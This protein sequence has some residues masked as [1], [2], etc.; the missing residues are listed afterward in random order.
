MPAKGVRTA[1][2]E[3]ALIELIAARVGT[4]ATVRTGVGDDCAVLAGDP[5]LVLGHDMIVEGVDFRWST[6]APE[7]V[8]H[9]ALAVNLSDLAAM[10]AE[11]MAALVGLG[12]GPGLDERRAAGLYDGMRDLG[13]P[14]GCPVVGGDVSDSAETV[15]AVTVVGRMPTGV[16]P[17]LRSGGRPGDAV[18]VT[19]ALGASWAGLML[20]EDPALAGTVPEADA[21]ALRRAHRR[22]IPQ[23][24]AGQRLARAGVHALMDCSDGLPIDL[25]RL[26]RASGLRARLDLDR[27]PTAPGVTA[28]C[29]EL[30]LPADATA[31][32]GG[33]DLVL[34]ACLPPDAVAPVARA[35]GVALHVVG[36]LARGEP[37]LDVRRGGLPVT[38]ATPG[39]EHGR[40]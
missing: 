11:P 40:G 39:W 17:A 27:V 9:K 32:A 16:A 22:P 15:L 24:A 18:C 36:R 13:D 25:E 10:G 2:R 31:A 19:G 33:E 21:T 1:V 30:G 12:V 3:S 8:G 5:P 26:A 14:V 35:T 29:A 4:S 38:L 28:L 23:L 7:D 20:L 34:I 37:G 6:F